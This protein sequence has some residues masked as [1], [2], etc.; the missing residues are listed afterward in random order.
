M[1]KSLNRVPRNKIAFNGQDFKGVTHLGTVTTAE[2]V[3][4]QVHAI[5]CMNDGKA[6]GNN[7]AGL[8][9][10]YKEYKFLSCVLE[11]I[12]AVSPGVADGGSEITLG[13]NDNPEQM[14]SQTA[15]A[16]ATLIGNLGSERSMRSFNAW[17]RFTYHVPL[18]NRKKQFDV[19]VNPGA[20]ITDVNV[21]DRSI[22]GAI[23]MGARSISA[24]ATLGHFKVNYVVRLLGPGIVST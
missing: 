17:E 15:A 14:V 21:V 7:F 1:R 18:T 3:M 22:Q 16:P 5:A 11:W 9:N 8:F 4:S 12:P 6:I 2:N 13:Y 24:I 10:F 20:Y 23:V 19:D